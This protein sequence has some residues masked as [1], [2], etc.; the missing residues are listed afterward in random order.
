MPSGSIT[1]RQLWLDVLEG[2]SH[3]LKHGYFC[4]R[5]P[6][7]EARLNRLSHV[8]AR[9]IEAEFFNTTSPWMTSTARA[10]DRLGTPN[11]VV[12]I[13]KLLAMKVKES[14]AH[15]T[16][17]IFT[18]LTNDAS[19]SLPKLKE[20][21][22]K[23]QQ[24]CAKDLAELP[25]VTTGDPPLFVLSE[26]TEFSETVRQ[27]VNGSPRRY[28]KVVQSNNN[29]YEDFARNIRA[30]APLFI[31]FERS[32]PRALNPSR[33][34]VNKP[35]IVRSEKDAVKGDSKSDIKGTLGEAVGLKTR[36]IYLDDVHKLVKECVLD[37]ACLNSLLQLSDLSVQSS[38][39]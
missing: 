31:P 15:L 14:C 32:D 7:D 23:L 25:P 3:P 5:Q 22:T 19:H 13:S 2:R 37:S 27:H 38:H 11:L 20:N 18:N 10:Q 36:K 4:T 30:T 28:A 24:Q 12:Y 33:E 29:A 39:A 8:K 16:C 9:D 17:P 6:D 34:T 1:S 26:I 21:V 35:T